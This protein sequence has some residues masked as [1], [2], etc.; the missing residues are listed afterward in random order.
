M[1]QTISQLS[2]KRLC[3]RV[4]IKR[5]SIDSYKPLYQYM[6]SVLLDLVDKIKTLSKSNKTN[7]IN[8]QDVEEARIVLSLLQNRIQSGGDVKDYPGFCDGMN[9]QCGNIPESGQWII[10]GVVVES[11]CAGAP[12]KMNGGGVK[13]EHYFTIPLTQFE[14]FVSQHLP[15]NFTFHFSNEG[16]DRLQYHIENITMQ[17]LADTNKTLQE[18]NIKQ[19]FL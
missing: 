6:I 3:H 12:S 13:N 10:P 11:T 2:L 19:F 1:K 15:N 4:G 9:S 16:M 8:E 17:Y 7:I 14:R 18:Q 5:I